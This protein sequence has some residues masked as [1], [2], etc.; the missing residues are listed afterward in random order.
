[1]DING[2]DSL[3]IEEIKTSNIIL[4]WSLEKKIFL[5][6]V[7]P[8]YN[9]TLIF[10]KTIMQYISMGKKVLYITGEYE[11][12]VEI[13]KYFKDN[14]KFTQYTYLKNSVNSSNL[15]LI[16]CNYKKAII[17]KDRF[18]LIIYDDIRSYPV[19]SKYEIIDIMNKCCN[20]YGK[21]ITYSV[22]DIFNKGKE[23]LLPVKYNKIPLVEPR[24][25]TTRIDINKDMPFVVY[26]YIKWSINIGRRVTIMLPENISI[27]NVTSY[28]FKYC[29]TLTHNIMY[30]SK[31]DDNV[32]KINEIHR[33]NQGI[34]ITNDFD[35]VCIDNSST[36]I[37]VLFADNSEF[38]YK[39]LVYFCGRTGEGDIGNRGEVIFL[40]KEEN[41]EIE[42]AK[43]ITRN[44][45]KKA[46]EDGLLSL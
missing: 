44:F 11:N 38:N 13:I 7:A 37:I 8:P 20:K 4:S 5:S 22:D 26:E 16:F 2:L 17:I 27:F 3:S 35:S 18:D 39:K 33:Y 15:P 45:N 40:A 1:M 36:N 12:Y 42:K 43:S 31:Y 6:V 24:I 41:Y 34:I 10:I 29:E 25:I 28:V 23:I 32:N 30:Y 19:Y 14:T 46:W 9:T 21:L